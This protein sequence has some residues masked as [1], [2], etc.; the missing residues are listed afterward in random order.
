M[1]SGAGV[2]GPGVCVVGKGGRRTVLLVRLRPYVLVLFPKHFEYFGEQIRL[3][4]IIVVLYKLVLCEAVA[5]KICVVG[6]L[7]IWRLQVDQ[8]IAMERRVMEKCYMYYTFCE[9]VILLYSKL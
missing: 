9:G 6:R 5:N 1:A 3:L 4:I 7:N 2:S 8:V